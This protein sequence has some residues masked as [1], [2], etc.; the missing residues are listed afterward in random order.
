MLVIRV[1]I[2]KKAC[3]NSRQKKQSDQGL[4]CL[5]G[6]FGW[7]QVFEILEPLRQPS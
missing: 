4:H 1:G 6:I 3:Q 7:Q 5:Q 2:L